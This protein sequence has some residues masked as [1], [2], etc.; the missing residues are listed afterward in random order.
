MSIAQTH[1][2]EP[3][4][5]RDPWRW[6]WMLSLLLPALVAAG[7]ALMWWSSEVTA[8]WW[9]LLFLYVAVPLADYAEHYGLE[10]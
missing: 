10:G 5:Y 6:V 2:S 7:P 9:P 1:T 8:L 3:E 4:I